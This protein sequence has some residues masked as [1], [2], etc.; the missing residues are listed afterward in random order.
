[1]VLF[2]SG[3]ALPLQFHLSV[4]IRNLCTFAILKNKNYET[5]MLLP[6]DPR[7]STVRQLFRAK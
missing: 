1:M 4:C 6:H 5:F 3:T 7:H 2:F